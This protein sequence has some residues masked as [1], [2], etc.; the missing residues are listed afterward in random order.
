MDKVTIRHLAGGFFGGVLG[1][2]AFGYF[3]TAL[4]VV[5]CLVGSAGGFWHDVVWQTIV[6]ELQKKDRRF[7]APHPLFFAFATE[8][9][10]LVPL[11]ISAGAFLI[12]MYYVAYLLAGD[13]WMTITWAVLWG[14]GTVFGFVFNAMLF[15]GTLNKDVFRRKAASARDL[16]PFYE[17]WQQWSEKSFGRYMIEVYVDLLKGQVVVMAFLFGLF[18]F[19][20]AAIFVMI[21]PGFVIAVGC[22]LGKGTVLAVRR[23]GY[24]ICFVVSLTT[25]TSFIYL[26][27]GR[28]GDTVT[29]LVTA[30]AVGAVSA[31]GSEAIHQGMRWLLAHHPYLM[32]IGRLKVHMLSGA[33]METSEDYLEKLSGKVLEAMSF[34]WIQPKYLK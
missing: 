27:Y 29:L 13:T 4:M 12:G 24:W 21:L 33:Y 1:I 2:L 32:K 30:L 16:K 20:L 10:M 6:S 7:S 23:G 28:L 14:I 34:P 15:V 25:T 18:C 17:H 26:M 19:I 9:L 22:G 31:A 3:G 5:G 11:C 8:L